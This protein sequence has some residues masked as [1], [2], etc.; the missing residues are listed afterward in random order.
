[1]RVREMLHLHGESMPRMLL[2]LL[3]MAALLWAWGPVRA[4]DSPISAAAQGG[5]LQAVREFI[6][7]GAEVD[8]P[9]TDG[10][11]A[12]LWAAYYSDAQLV[13]ALIAAG[14]DPDTANNF[15]VT[16]L[17]QASSTGDAPVMA[18]LLDGGADPALSHPEGLTPLMAAAQTGHVEAVSLLLE[19]GADPNAADSFQA[20]TPLMWAAAEGHLEV[21]DALLAA[22]ADPDLQARVSSLTERKN[23]D[24]P[25]G[26]F[27]ALMFAAR[28]GHEDVVRRLV[29]AGASL[30]LTNG[31]GATAMM[32]TIVNDRFDLTAS[33]IELGADVNDGSLY[34]AVQ[35]RDATTDWYA[36]DGSQLRANHDNEHTALDLIHLLLEAGADPNQTFVGQLHSVSM[37]CDVYSN[38]SPFYRAAIAADV[39]ALKLLIQYGADV[40]WTPAKVESTNPTANDNVG[41]APLLVAMVG[42]KGV[43]L[44]A[45][46]GYNREGRA[47]PFREPS[48]RNQADAVRVLLEA[49]ANPD[50]LTP[51]DQKGPLDSVDFVFGGET[52]LHGAT[53]T[54]KIDIIRVLAEFGATL[55]MPDRNGL[56]PLYLAENPLPDDPVNPFNVDSDLGDATDEEVA[57]VLR[58]LMQAASVADAGGSSAQ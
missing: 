7:A 27:S 6:D 49:G 13:T 40:E 47:P 17:L 25:S 24:F 56:T 43:P 14:A 8:A 18:A 58:E 20:Q 41:R 52:A 19:H 48:N 9:A 57:A 15:G 45:G 11:T 38:A 51:D 29:D 42:G 28:N 22:G 44:S 54:R 16:P 32:I 26:G 46:P 12:L 23:A 34:Q 3:M 55:D 1:M 2:G 30:D 36:R 35:M 5:D 53:R 4:A 10:S 50:V 31:D 21:V 33:L 39:E 37:C